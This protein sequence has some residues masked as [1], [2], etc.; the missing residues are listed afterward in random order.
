M[1][2]SYNQGG[3][4]SPH[5]DNTIIPLQAQAEQEQQDVVALLRNR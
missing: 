1:V 2:N 3:C 5:Q 4:Q